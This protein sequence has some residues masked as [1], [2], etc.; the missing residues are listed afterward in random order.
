VAGAV[1]HVCQ[2]TGNVVKPKRLEVKVPAGVEDGSRVRIAGEGQAGVAGGAKGDLYLVISVRQDPRFQ[3]KGADL[4]VD[5]EVPLTLAVLGGE[6][7][8]P[9]MTGSVMLKVPE[10]TQNGKVFRLGGLGMP[11][12]KSKERGDLYAKLHVKLPEVLDEKQRRLFEE[13][14]ESGG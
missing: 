8:V 13:L 4:H 2:G 3:R 7:E 11:R 1:C 14:K 12:L 5:I 10:L 9:T 6:I